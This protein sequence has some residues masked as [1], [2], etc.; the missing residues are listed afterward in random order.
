M[1]F[2]LFFDVLT[3]DSQLD[4]H[5]FSQNSFQFFLECCTSG[6][7]CLISSKRAS[8]L[9]DFVAKPCM[10]ARIFNKF[11]MGPSWL[12]NFATQPQ[13]H[14]FTCCNWSKFLLFL[15]QI[16]IFFSGSG[17]ADFPNGRGPN[18]SSESSHAPSKYSYQL[19]HFRTRCHLCWNCSFAKFW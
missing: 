19:I 3:N 7:E 1:R 18:S 17:K 9:R 15:W 8:S 10:S 6:F 13:R 4:L 16:K 12:R 11:S 14:V 5:I 2:T